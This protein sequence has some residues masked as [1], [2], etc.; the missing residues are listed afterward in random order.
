MYFEKNEK[1]MKFMHLDLCEFSIFT[2]LRPFRCSDIEIK[3]ASG[4]VDSNLVP[5][6]FK[7]L[8]LGHVILV[9][10]IV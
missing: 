1:I 3:K 10:C 5:G 4:P 9:L 2:C 6:S 8:D 7:F